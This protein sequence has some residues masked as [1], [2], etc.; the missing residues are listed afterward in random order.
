MD[1]MVPLPISPEALAAFCQEWKIRSLYVFGSALRPED[2][3]DDSDFDLIAEFEPEAPWGLFDLM[4]LEWEL[5]D[6]VGRRTEVIERK[7]IEEDRNYIRREH[8]LGEARL[9]YAA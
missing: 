8:I 5:T 6:L 3:N 9:L 1:T 7:A 4:H 2:F